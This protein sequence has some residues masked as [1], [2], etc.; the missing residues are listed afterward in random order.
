MLQKLLFTSSRTGK[1]KALTEYISTTRDPE[2]GLALAALTGDLNL[3][4]L[5]PKFYKELIQDFCDPEL[6][7]LSYDYVGD[8]AETVSLMWPNSGND[9]PFSISLGKFIEKVGNKSK[10]E[11]RTL[12]KDLMDKFSSDERW[13]MIKLTTGGFRVG[14]SSKLVKVALALYG[15]KEVSEI[16]KLW[17]GLTFPYTSLFLWLENKGA[18]PKVDIKRMFHPPMLAN[19]FD[20]NKEGKILN[21]EDFFAEWKWDGIRVQLVISDDI[22]RLF[23]RSGEDISSAFMDVINEVSGDAV[24][25]GELLV[26]EISRP[27][28]FNYLQKRLNRKQTSKRLVTELPAFIRVYDILFANGRDL[29]EISLSQRKTILNRWLTKNSSKKLDLSKM[30]KIKSWVELDRLR[31]KGAS[32]FDHEGVMI[33]R[34]SSNYLTGRQKGFWFKWKKNPLH[35]DA[36]LMYAQRGHGRRSSFY[37]DY[38]FGIW[39]GKTIVPIGKA[40]FGFTDLELKQLDDWVRKNTIKRFGPVREVKKELVLEIAFDSAH[41]SE[42]HKSGIALRFPRVHRIR[43]EKPS[44]EADQLDDFKKH[45]IKNEL[46]LE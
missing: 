17:P 10:L 14:V 28:P 13:A 32:N 24:L 8:L 38:T 6:F 26:G 42:R 18:K 35:V 7:R 43:W 29:R 40:Y 25:D 34:K 36:V 11:Q 39:R 22:K 45:F 30:W 33:K 3:K 37:S 23:S 46:T 41:M 12:I 15:K 1:L 31:Q 2:R 19:P 20:F 44:F 27:L 16:E 5:S 4:S 21:P 9:S